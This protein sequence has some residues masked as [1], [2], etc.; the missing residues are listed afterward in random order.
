MTEHVY[1]G[2]QPIFDRQ[3]EVVGYE[4]LYRS[5]NTQQA[6]FKDGNHATS[7]V[8]SN[9]FLE[10]GLERLVGDKLA[11]INLTAAFLLG[12]YPIPLQ[13]DRL[14]L[15][16]LEDVTVN[17]E[18][19][20]A[21]QNLIKRGYT[22]ALDD[23]T[24]P[25]H[26]ELIL[27]LAKIVKVDFMHTDRSLLPDQVKFYKSRNRLL[28]AEK[29]ETQEEFEFCK[30]LGF[31]YFQGYFLAKPSVVQEK[32]LSSSKMIIMQL[33]AEMQIPDIEFNRIDEVIRQDLGLSY[34]L[35]RL[36]NS[37]Y[38]S[39]R[40]EV[41][42]IKQALT[43][44]GLKQIQS[45]V[46]LLLLSESDNKPSELLKTALIRGKMAELISETCGEDRTDT[47]FTLGLFSV[48][49]AL[50]D[51]PLAEILEQIPLA[52]ELKAALLHQQGQ[53]GNLLKCILAYEQ[54]VWEQVEYR[55]L[56]P[57]HI[58]GSYLEAVNWAEEMSA[59]LY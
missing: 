28:L 20:T 23:V 5:G 26:V 46:S 43:L 39:T 3:L 32:K 53:A 27:D 17:Q 19:A 12:D 44:L 50:L 8:I 6:I 59:A 57:D 31:D 52:A 7:V 49:D 45:W 16:V 14:V 51:M 41:K 9:A 25:N 18:L 55:G 13:Y 37:A 24:D 47:S 54:G 10:I 36:I 21:L 4:L 29:I 56:E 42:S 22:V 11:F 33:L 1:I 2:R 40:S 48:L 34:K 30:E 35:L 15:E 38:F 58:L